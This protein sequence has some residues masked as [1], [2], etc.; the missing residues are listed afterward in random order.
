MFFQKRRIFAVFDQRLISDAVQGSDRVIFRGRPG[1]FQG[2][3]REFPLERSNK[4]PGNTLS[5]P[6]P[7]LIADLFRETRAILKKGKIYFLALR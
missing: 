1:R 6:S 4:D 5:E 2:R 7:D 3:L